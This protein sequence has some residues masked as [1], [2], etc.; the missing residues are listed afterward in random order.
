MPSADVAGA[1]H[2]YAAV[3]GN[4][5]SHLHVHLLARYP[6]TPREFWGLN[7]DEWPGAGRGSEPQVAGF[8][9]RLRACLARPS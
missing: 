9:A 4:R 2:V 1:D 8:V 5:A 3:L 7:A 6:G